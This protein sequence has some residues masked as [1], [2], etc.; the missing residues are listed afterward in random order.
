MAKMAKRKEEDV[1]Y[2]LC[3]MFDG[4]GGLERDLTPYPRRDCYGARCQDI[5]AGVRPQDGN[6][7]FPVD[8][9]SRYW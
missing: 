5:A 6:V 4:R 3:Q 1:I 7:D 2:D 9:A 8:P